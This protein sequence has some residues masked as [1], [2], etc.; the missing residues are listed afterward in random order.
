MLLLFFLDNGGDDNKGRGGFSGRGRGGGRG[1]I[2]R[3][4]EFKIHFK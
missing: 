3:D 2:S 4:G 1:G